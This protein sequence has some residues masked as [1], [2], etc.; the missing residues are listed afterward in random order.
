M[1]TLPVYFRKLPRLSIAHSIR[2]SV[3][4][5]NYRSIA[6]SIGGKKLHWTLIL[7]SAI[8]GT[9]GALIIHSEEKEN[10]RV[11]ATATK[12]VLMSVCEDKLVSNL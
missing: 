2:I 5:R 9:T 4:Y 3:S 12:S 6:T 7:L 1:A 8:R 10:S 11:R